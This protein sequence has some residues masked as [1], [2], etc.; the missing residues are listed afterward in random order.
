MLGSSASRYDLTAVASPQGGQVTVGAFAEYLVRACLRRAALGQDGR[1]S[2]RRAFEALLQGRRREYAEP[3]DVAAVL[4]RLNFNLNTASTASAAPVEGTGSAAPLA[5]HFPPLTRFSSADNAAKSRRGRSTP[6]L[7]A[8][9][10]PAHWNYLMR[11]MGFIADAEHVFAQGS[12]SSLPSRTSLRLGDTLTSRGSRGGGM[13][14][15]TG[16]SV[17][18][19][20]AS[21]PTRGP[22]SRGPV[23]RIDYATFARFFEE[24]GG[25][26]E[27][28]ERAVLESL[29]TPDTSRNL[30]ALLRMHDH[31]AS[32]LVGAES[33]AAAICE[34][35]RGQGAGPWTEEVAALLADS[36]ARPSPIGPA[37]NHAALLRAVA[38][39]FGVR[40]M[41]PYG[42]FYLA[43]HPSTSMAEVDDMMEKRLFWLF[44]DCAGTGGR[45]IR[46]VCLSRHF[47][48]IDIKYRDDQCVGRVF[49]ESEMLWV[50]DV[51][52]HGRFEYANRVEQALGG[53]GLSKRKRG[54]M[55]EQLNAARH[56]LQQAVRRRRAQL[57]AA[58]D[59]TALGGARRRRRRREDGVPASPRALGDGYGYGAPN[60]LAQAVAAEAADPIEA[61]QG[62]PLTTQL[63]AKGYENVL[64]SGMREYKKVR[65]RLVREELVAAAYSKHKH[66][67][68]GR[69]QADSW[70]ALQVSAFVGGE[71]E[72]S[73]YCEV[74]ERL[75][76]TGHMLLQMTDADY[77]Q[78][79]VS[80]P[81][82][83]K[84]LLERVAELAAA[85]QRRVDKENAKETKRAQRARKK[86]DK[87]AVAAEEQRRLQ[88]E[89]ADRSSTG[90]AQQRHVAR[91]GTA[92]AQQS[93]DAA[94]EPTGSARAPHRGATDVELAEGE[95]LS[96]WGDAGEPAR[97]PSV[98]ALPATKH[99]PKQV[100][101]EEQR[102][103]TAATPAARVPSNAEVSLARVRL[104]AEAD[105]AAAEERASRA[106][107]VAAATRGDAR[108]AS[109]ERSRSPASSRSPRAR[110]SPRSPR[111]AL[112]DAA[113][114]DA[115]MPREVHTAGAVSPRVAAPIPLSPYKTR[116][117]TAIAAV[118]RRSDHDDAAGHLHGDVHASMS[119]RA[120]ADPEGGVDVE[121]T[122][123]LAASA[124]ADG[125]RDEVARNIA[126]RREAEQAE[127]DRIE[128]RRRFEERRS[129]QERRRRARADERKMRL[130][131]ERDAAAAELSARAAEMAAI[132]AEKAA[133]AA[134]AAEDARMEAVRS[135]TRARR[136]P[137]SARG[138][139]RAASP[140]Q[141]RPATAGMSRTGYSGVDAAHV[142]SDE[143]L[144]RWK[145]VDGGSASATLGASSGTLA[146]DT[147]RV[148]RAAADA[149]ARARNDERRERDEK[150]IAAA[151]A[152]EEGDVDVALAD[153]ARSA[154]VDVDV[155]L[156]DAARAAR[157]EAEPP[158]PPQP[159]SADV[160]RNIAQETMED[161]GAPPLLDEAA[162]EPAVDELGETNAGGKGARRRRLKV[163]GARSV[164]HGS[165]RAG[166]EV[167]MHPPAAC[168]LMASNTTFMVVGCDRLSSASSS[169]RRTSPSWRSMSWR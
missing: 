96:G 134:R 40:C 150:E 137:R 3:R 21:S 159:S 52:A 89:R 167:R 32:G 38:A 135:R 79:G 128:R 48:T 127:L 59:S 73:Q 65:E 133:L 57:K 119:A 8:A 85:V 30:G 144:A 51:L 80:H 47:G 93:A 75:N 55:T 112:Y 20:A 88:A 7:V 116:P 168:V 10:A 157:G 154:G 62:A 6:A 37:V 149:V 141:G 155:A 105:A 130:R 114:R 34:A 121:L 132:A 49:V 84:K 27:E 15:T 146:V 66:A 152:R 67:M 158:P 13:R 53:A 153:A 4:R 143:S 101:T 23:L 103:Q 11:R 165:V 145:S 41:T 123:D 142:E 104:R 125:W 136:R 64:E 166:V 91:E 124:G 25:M 97:P 60:P 45:N 115:H 12:A 86:E 92:E 120:T 70:N 35:G 102:V 118:G 138:V 16:S 122:R 44:K 46:G 113:A 36:W 69:S 58:H 108:S 74:L 107:A 129:E 76:V 99:T 50:K 9:R 72:L 111:S 164:P 56:E 33:A 110:R 139:R 17:S 148:E 100:V 90:A 162:S 31:S 169:S 22:A 71:L 26:S 126:R 29:S 24:H 28:I 14:P 147:E 54:E 151:F 109:S 2:T 43:L 140:S 163:A 61:L 87:A 161:V 117:A 98:P 19:G 42:A 82:H 1:P 63:V 83:R 18:W 5:C 106:R 95:Q 77:R 39:P 156:A 81:M 131:A 94:T 78:I 68:G 160:M